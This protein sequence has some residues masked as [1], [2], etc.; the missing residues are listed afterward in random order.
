MNLSRSV[1]Q[2]IHEVLWDE[3]YPAGEALRRH[4]TKFIHFM[5]AP[6]TKQ[7]APVV[8]YLSLNPKKS[9]RDPE[10]VYFYPCR[11]LLRN[12][13]TFQ[14]GLT[15]DY[16]AIVDVV[17]SRTP[18]IVN[19]G[20]MSMNRAAEIARENGW[21]ERLWKVYE[22]PSWYL[23]ENQMPARL[24]KRRSPGALFYGTCDMLVNRP[25]LFGEPKGKYRWHAL[26]RGVRGLYDPGR[27][28]INQSE[29]AQLV[30]F[31][32]RLYRNRI[33]EVG[34][35]RQRYGAF[36][37]VFQ[38]VIRR[39]GGVSRVRQ[40]RVT[41]R[42]AWEGH[43]VD[44][45][46]DTRSSKIVLRYGRN[47]REAVVDLRMDFEV[48]YDYP[49]S[50]TVSSLAYR[51]ESHLK[52]MPPDGTEYGETL[53]DRDRLKALVLSLMDGS[54]PATVRLSDEGDLIAHARGGM[55]ESTSS[56]YAVY[57]KD[58]RLRV[59]AGTHGLKPHDLKYERVYPADV[60]EERAVEDFEEA[61][62]DWVRGLP[63]VVS[64][65]MHPRMVLIQLH[66]PLLDRPGFTEDDWIEWELKRTASARRPAEKRT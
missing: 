22:H 65:E 49:A 32:P 38:E 25:D 53:W 29:P 51:V 57:T 40:G 14:Y 11:W 62:E 18:G 33:V 3:R 41:G 28:I 13:R 4:P 54:R 37:E 20:R 26:L 47:G 39:L 58:G 15:M 61:L 27:G 16:Y 23:E 6:E 10:G 59:S 7:R 31:D 17:P 36:R 9:H 63:G 46:F 50:E 42:I 24:W 12:Y 60:S 19:L 44:V 1:L 21:E 56:V 45:E 52:R 43:P 5:N 55:Y 34:S 30:L 64:G 2:S 35:N 8:P 66:L 48:L